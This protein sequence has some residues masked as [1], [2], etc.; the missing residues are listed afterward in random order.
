M[1]LGW[2]AT[3]GWLTVRLMLDLHGC[4]LFPRLPP[5]IRS[6]GYFLYRRTAF[7]IVAHLFKGEFPSR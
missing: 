5:V 6:L 3:E 2:E 1:Q 4:D 7:F